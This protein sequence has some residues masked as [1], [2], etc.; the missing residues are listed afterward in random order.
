MSIEATPSASWTVPS[1]SR[2]S[3]SA[4][5]PDEP[6]ARLWGEWLPAGAVPA[7]IFNRGFD[8][9]RLM[10]VASALECVR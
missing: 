4:V 1:A 7:R 10:A 8:F 3:F 5:V 2:T 6:A 9:G